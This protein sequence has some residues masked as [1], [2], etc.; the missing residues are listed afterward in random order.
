MPPEAVSSGSSRS[1]RISVLWFMALTAVTAAMLV[2]ARI[3]NDRTPA[4]ILSLGDDKARHVLAYGV[5]SALLLAGLRR[6]WPHPGRALVGVVLAAATISALDEFTQPWWGRTCS[7][8][9]FCASLLGAVLGAAAVLW[10]EMFRQGR[11]RMPIQARRS[12]SFALPRPA[13]LTS[14]EETLPPGEATPSGSGPT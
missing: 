3:P 5:W 14:P 11:R 2:L 13:G 1:R 7:V 8:W 4:W 10:W 12:K 6:G 9:D